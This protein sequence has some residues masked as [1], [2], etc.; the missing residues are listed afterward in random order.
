MADPSSQQDRTKV[1]LKNALSGKKLIAHC[2]SKD[3]D[4]GA[5]LVEEGTSFHWSFKTLLLGTTLYWC[6]LAVEDRRLS[7]TAYDEDDDEIRGYTVRW[8]V[9][10]D[11]AHLVLRSDHEEEPIARQK[12]RRI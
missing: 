1:D 2:R 7:F 11:G 10:D 9:R 6:N 5:Q 8:V 12:W 3:D 4:L